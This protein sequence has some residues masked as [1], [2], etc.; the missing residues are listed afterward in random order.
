MP[1]GPG[2]SLEVPVEV[3]LGTIPL[4]KTESGTPKLTVKAAARQL[5]EGAPMDSIQVTKGG[6]SGRSPRPSPR[7][8]PRVS[9]WKVIEG[10]IG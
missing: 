5:E 2:K 7:P 4:R 10:V 1:S 9:K 3:I 8:S 6:K